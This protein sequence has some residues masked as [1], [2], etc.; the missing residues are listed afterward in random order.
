MPDL[1]VS[2]PTRRYTL[3]VTMLMSLAAVPTAVVL[4]AGRAALDDADSLP[5]TT[6]LLGAAPGAPIAVVPDGGMTGGSS[7]GVPDAPSPAARH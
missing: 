7:G 1:G 3:I 6:P 4:G 2:G 5:S